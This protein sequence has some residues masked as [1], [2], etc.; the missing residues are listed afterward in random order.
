MHNTRRTARSVEPDKAGSQRRLLLLLQ[1]QNIS[2]KKQKQPTL[3][4]CVL[5]S[6][7]ALLCNIATEKIHWFF[8]RNRN[9]RKKFNK[10]NSNKTW[11]HKNDHNELTFCVVLKRC[12]SVDFSNPILTRCYRQR[13]YDVVVVVVVVVVGGVWRLFLRYEQNKIHEK[14]NKRERNTHFIIYI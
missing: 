6:T 4:V 2:S 7:Y 12:A 3:F 10:K 1:T 8:R 5:K 11:Q 14:T 13:F 9:K